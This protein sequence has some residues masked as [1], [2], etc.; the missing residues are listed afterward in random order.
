LL[1]DECG[2]EREAKTKLGSHV[3]ETSE[4]TTP[5]IISDCWSGHRICHRLRR[6]PEFPSKFKPIDSANVKNDLDDNKAN[7]ICLNGP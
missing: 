7:D 6:M 4:A 3:E 5:T 2:N 1:A